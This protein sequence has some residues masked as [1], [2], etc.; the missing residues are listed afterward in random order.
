MAK[1]YPNL[2][3]ELSGDLVGCPSCKSTWEGMRFVNRDMETDFFSIK[4]ALSVCVRCYCG[5]WEGPIKNLVELH[6]GGWNKIIQWW[7]EATKTKLNDCQIIV[8]VSSNESVEE[9]LKEQK[10]NN[11]RAIFG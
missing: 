1:W 11:L 6:L 2:Y 3:R 10:D 4:E 5:Y 7:E 9:F 8:P